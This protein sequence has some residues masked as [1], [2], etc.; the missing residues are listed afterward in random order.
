MQKNAETY[1]SIMKNSESPENLNRHFGLR[2]RRISV[3]KNGFLSIVSD[4]FSATKQA[5]QGQ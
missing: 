4:D 1:L 2:I 5:K 3:F